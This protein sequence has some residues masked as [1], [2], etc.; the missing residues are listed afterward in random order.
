M[1]ENILILNNNRNI[2]P[3]AKIMMMYKSD[4]GGNKIAFQLDDN[5]VFVLPHETPEQRDA[6]FEII[7]MKLDRYYKNGGK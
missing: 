4:M 2:I 3:I 1:L 5:S 6:L 7:K